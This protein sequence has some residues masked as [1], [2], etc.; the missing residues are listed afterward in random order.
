MNAYALNVTPVNGNAMLYGA[1]AA[2]QALTAQG[3]PSLHIVSRPV[4]SIMVMPATGK[5]LLARLGRGLS[6][7]A[8]TAQA[9]GYLLL[10]AVSDVA[11]MALTGLADGRLIP[12]A[13]GTAVMA[14]QSMGESAQALLGAGLARLSLDGAGRLARATQGTG[15]GDLIM[16]GT[17]GIP[18]PMTRPDA[19]A[20]AH[21]SRVV[22]VDGDADLFAPAALA[23]TLTITA[24]DRIVH[25]APERNH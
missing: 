7:M 14:L 25:V 3:K 21:G 16:T 18:H 15:D 6:G 10:C 8:I 17:L 20:R 4:S 1:G 12:V 2:A 11:L 24:E 22:R 5:G 23:R 13:R 9:Q 19:F